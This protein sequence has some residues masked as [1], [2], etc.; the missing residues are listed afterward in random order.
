MTFHTFQCRKKSETKLEAAGASKQCCSRKEAGGQSWKYSYCSLFSIQYQYSYKYILI[1]WVFVSILIKRGQ[2]WKY[3]YCSLFS[4]L[5]I[6]YS[7]L[8]RRQ[9]RKYSYYS[10]S[11][12][13]LVSILIIQYSHCWYSYSSRGQ[14]R[15]YSY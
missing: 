2:S 3:S 15:K 6:E 10:V 14:A 9:S 1:N 8:L 11:A 5:I 7:Y 4:I 13:L 12:F